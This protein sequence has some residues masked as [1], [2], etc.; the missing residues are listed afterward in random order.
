MRIASVITF[1][2]LLATA[3][4]FAQEATEAEEEERPACENCGMFWDTS[5]TRVSV[6]I[7]ADEKEEEHIFECMSCTH[8]GLVEIYGDG[9]ELASLQVLDY[10]TFGAEEETMIDGMK[11]FYL[12]GVER[13]KGSMPPYIA[14][15][16]SE[17]AAKE[18]QKELG[19]ELLDFAGVK[20]KF[21]EAEDEE[22]AGKSKSEHPNGGME[23]PSGRPEHP[24]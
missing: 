8:T 23:H 1:I 7:K 17:D 19:G 13:L 18:S 4:A 16:A 11:A 9:V 2:L 6:T 24:H 5:P 3:G 10:A 14:A 21:H 15:F 20:A 12:Y 22:E